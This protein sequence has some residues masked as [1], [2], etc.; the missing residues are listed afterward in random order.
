MTTKVTIENDKSSNGDVLIAG[1]NTTEDRVSATVFPGDKREVWITN[2]SVLVVT[3]RW[4]TE[5]KAAE[6]APPEAA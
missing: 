4:P 5:A 1:Y 2:N 6:K 3:E